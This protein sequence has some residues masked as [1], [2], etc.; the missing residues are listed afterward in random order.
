MPCPAS[1][2][3]NC[4]AAPSSR[5]CAVRRARSA[6]LAFDTAATLDMVAWNSTPSRTG[7]E[8]MDAM[9]FTAMSCAA[10]MPACTPPFI[11]M[12]FMRDCIA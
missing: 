7:A 5:A 1:A 2:A 10:P 12:S 3:E 8:N 6:A 9:F 4:V 11:A